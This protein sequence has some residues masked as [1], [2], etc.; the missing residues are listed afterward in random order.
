VAVARLRLTVSPG[1]RQSTIVGR[2]GD[3][4]KVRVSAPPER[5]RANDALL[6]LLAEALGVPRGDVR[7][8]H[9]E[10]SRHKTVDVEGLD[11]EEASRRLA[12]AVGPRSASC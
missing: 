5:G 12:A 7:L 10:S 8:A 4:W 6:T 9:G 1:A 2:H 3:G 11:D